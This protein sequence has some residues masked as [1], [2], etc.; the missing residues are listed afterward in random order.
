MTGPA[1][2]WKE[3]ATG[4]GIVAMIAAAIVALSF[5][6]VTL[7][8]GIGTPFLVAA[9]P[10]GLL[11]CALTW[12]AAMYLPLV[13][14]G[15][16]IFFRQN[17]ALAALSGVP[18]VDLLAFVL[19]VA[20]LARLRRRD[21][22]ATAVDAALILLL[23][24]GLLVVLI[25]SSVHSIAPEDSFTTIR[26]FTKDVI[27]AALIALSIRSVSDLWAFCGWLIFATSFSAVI[28]VH[29][30]FSGTS[31]FTTFDNATWQGALRS[32]GASTEAVPNVATMLLF[33]TLLSLVFSI[34]N[35]SAR[36]L[37][38][39][40]FILGATAIALSISRG[41]LVALGLGGLLLLWRLRKEAFFAKA[42]SVAMLAAIVGML[43]M[44]QPLITK[45]LATA[46]QSEDRTVA[47]R[48]SYQEIGLD[49]FKS[50]PV[51]GIGPGAYAEHYAS[52]RYRFVSGRG[53]EP[54]P[55][56][57]LYLQFAAETGTIGLM[58]FVGLIATVGMTFRRAAKYS[59]THLR[60]VAEGLFVAY[61]AMCFQFLFLS[62]KSFLGLW[63]MV[64]LSIA[65]ARLIADESRLRTGKPS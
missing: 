38:I 59:A 1:R 6:L 35:S 65:V 10:L 51:L 33:G 17:D 45:F 56:H 40:L 62:S 19:G 55:L 13:L 39:A 26:T 9:L 36:L 29:D 31:L 42:I 12:R 2:P 50:S 53:T 5:L 34:R 49:L 60:H 44:P 43:V 41:P 24:L 4:W 61:A 7:G 8:N 3:H 48:V 64:G 57:N 14:P 21:V 30:T 27:F 15:L 18:V 58:L 54:R 63:I 22:T 28:V 11:L 23:L 25:A 47:R 20:L 32:A 37:H 52:D 16:L 46:S